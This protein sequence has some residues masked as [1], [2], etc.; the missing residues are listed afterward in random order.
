MKPNRIDDDEIVHQGR[1]PPLIGGITATSSRSLKLTRPSEYSWFTANTAVLRTLS[2]P[3]CFATSASLS[4]SVWHSSSGR[5]CVSSASP[6]VTSLARAK[7]STLMRG[8]SRGGSA[9]AKR[10]R[11]RGDDAGGGASRCDEGAE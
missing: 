4:A 7:Y 2:N 6:P 8:I 9:V 10:I 11:A 5:S 3:G 1:H